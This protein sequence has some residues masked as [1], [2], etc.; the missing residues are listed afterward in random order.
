MPAGASLLGR[1]GAYLGSAYLPGPPRLLSL[2]EAGNPDVVRI[3]S[4]SSQGP[5]TGLE[6]AIPPPGHRPVSSSLPAHGDPRC[7]A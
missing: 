1:A 2:F 6:V 7:R 5:L 4:D 3:V